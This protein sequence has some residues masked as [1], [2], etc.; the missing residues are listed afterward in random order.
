[1]KDIIMDV[2]H[3]G[4]SRGHRFSLHHLSFSLRENEIVGILG[5]NGAGKTTALEVLAGL[6]EPEAGKVRF[7]FSESKEDVRRFIG[8]APENDSLW[9]ELSVE[10]QCRFVLNLYGK[11]D[12]QK[13]DEML[14]ELQLI[15]YRDIRA[16][17][18]SLG[19][20]KKLSLILSFL[21]D[22]CILI[23]D[24]PFN[25]LDLAGRSRLRRFLKTFAARPK[26]GVLLSSHQLEEVQKTAGRIL[27]LQEGCLKESFSMEDQESGIVDLPRYYHAVVGGD[28]D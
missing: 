2:S 3:L 7:S 10:E 28:D 20:R 22:P 8:Y 9:S 27:I 17:R 13:I 6:E 1:M 16:D 15:H 5:P 14:T 11:R 25:G 12:Q 18:L 21:H 23:L 26:K 24:E 4:R 19:N